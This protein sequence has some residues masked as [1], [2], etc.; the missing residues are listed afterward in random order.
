M[1]ILALAACRGEPVPRDYQN[2]PPD[3]TRAP[4]SSTQTPS[5]HG[6]GQPA[7]EPSTGHEGTAPQTTIP[8]TPPV[9][10]TTATT[11]ATTTT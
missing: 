9:T 11:A 3:M 10:T 4:Q 2:A 7:P 8:D 1:I 6:M 5:Q